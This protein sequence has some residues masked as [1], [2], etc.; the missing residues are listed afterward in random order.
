M[1]ERDY[2]E[3]APDED[4]AQGQ[5]TNPSTG[6]PSLEDQGNPGQ[7][8]APA[9]DDDTGVPHEQEMNEPDE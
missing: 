2:S 5:S 6:T 1:G 9:P 7:T 4:P 3:D 8:E